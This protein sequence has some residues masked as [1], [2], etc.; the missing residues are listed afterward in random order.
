M[1]YTQ[2]LVESVLQTARSQ[3]SGYQDDDEINR[4]IAMVESELMETLAPLYSTNQKVQ[5]LLA[6]FVTRPSTDSTVAAGVLTKPS[7]Y[8]QF[9][10]MTI[11]GKPVYERN[12]NEIDIINTSPTRKPTATGPYYFYFVNNS[13]NVLPATISSARITYIRKP[14][15]GQI[16][17][18]YVEEEDN[19]YA[20]ISV[21]RE[22]EW[23]DRAFNL[24]YYLLLE[25]YGVENQ[26]MLAMEYSQLG[27]NKEISKV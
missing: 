3:T 16:A 5:D 22:I 9:V 13:V 6:P 18:D 23:P 8:V 12:V 26:E 7:D 4:N 10:N 15:A 25:K 19:D 14:I 2:R 11:S 21:V 27:I 17:Y 1:A 24:L 20:I